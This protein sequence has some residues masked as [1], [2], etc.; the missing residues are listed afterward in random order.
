[1]ARILRSYPAFSPTQHGTPWVACVGSDGKII[2]KA[3]PQTGRYTGGYE[4]GK[5]GHLVIE[6]PS[7]GQVYAYGR[8]N[9]MRVE[10]TSRGRSLDCYYVIYLDGVF[11]P[12]D[13]YGL[14]LD[15]WSMPQRLK[16]EYAK[17]R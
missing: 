1:M 7:H 6:C 13:R 5:K 3:K 12:C 2:F 17:L 10:T 4:T 16:K 14:L 9:R 15:V 8:K 11:K